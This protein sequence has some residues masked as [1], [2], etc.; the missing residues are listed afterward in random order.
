MS[1][2]CRTMV[3][4][5]GDLVSVRPSGLPGKAVLL[6]FCDDVSA[7]SFLCLTRDEANELAAALVLLAESSGEGRESG[8]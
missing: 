5:D 7:S 4:G 6:A 1:M 8:A 3:T 2:V